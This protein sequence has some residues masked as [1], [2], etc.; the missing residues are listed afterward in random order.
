MSIGKI[1]NIVN[2]VIEKYE[3]VRLKWKQAVRRHRSK[4]VRKAVDKRDL[5]T[6]G[7]FVRHVLK[8]RKSRWDSS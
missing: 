3:I 8:K 5:R 7:D 4:R 6:L 2:W 1:I